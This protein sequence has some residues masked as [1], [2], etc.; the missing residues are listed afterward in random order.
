[1]SGQVLRD[2]THPLRV[3]VTGHS[4]FVGRRAVAAL[5]AAGHDVR[6]LET[7]AG[8]PVDLIDAEAVHAAFARIRPERVLHLGAVSGPMLLAD[9]PDLVLRINGEGTATVLEAA[10]AVCTV[11][12]VFASSVAAHAAPSG[13]DP[14][15]L[16]LYGAT[17]RFGEMLARLAERNGNLEVPIV[18]I[19]S[20][21]GSG[22][23]TDNPIHAMVHMALR[24]RVVRYA[25]RVMEPFI[26]AGDC[27]AALAGITVAGRTRPAY[28]AIA[29]RASE[30][31]VAALVAR[32]TGARLERVAS[33][34]PAPIY[35][36]RFD[37]S[38]LLEDAALPGFLP[39]D[40]AINNLVAAIRRDANIL[41]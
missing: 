9:R 28:D 39:L 20:V 22:R 17:K 18:R 34:D 21:F 40:V 31:E 36:R 6:G 41:V 7:E 2:G 13:D 16:T 4:G 12:V 33:S 15:P 5:R 30:S 11:R 10:R 24:D 27:A 19:G 32:A 1:M 8:G 14:D 29:Y 35:S 25:E 3:L 26:E 38:G 37:A 23:Q